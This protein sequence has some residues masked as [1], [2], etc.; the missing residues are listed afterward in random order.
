MF[1][2]VYIN[3]I[4]EVEQ[5]YRFPGCPFMRTHKINWAQGVLKEGKEI[6]VKR[7]FSKSEQGVNEFFIQG[8]N[9]STN[10]HYQAIMNDLELAG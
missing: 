1:T 2:E 8:V 6:A 7:L 10:P 5:G 4:P 3:L 9:S